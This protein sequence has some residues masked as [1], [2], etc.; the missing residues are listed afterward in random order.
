[1]NLQLAFHFLNRPPRHI[2]RKPPNVVRYQLFNRP[3]HR[4]LSATR[5]P[6][7]QSY[8]TLFSHFRCALLCVLCVLRALCVKSLFLVFYSPLAAFFNCSISFPVSARNLPGSKSKTSGPIRTRRIFS[9]KCP[10]RS[11]ILRIC[12]FRP[13]IKTTSYQG[14]SPSSNNRIFAGEVFTRRPSSNS[15]TIPARKRSILFSSG[16]PLTFTKY[17]FGMCV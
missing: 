13:S 1:M 17:V 14:F 11:N 15:I 12:R 5:V 9:T 4:I 10:T 16:F 7:F 3:C 2:H 6:N 8:S